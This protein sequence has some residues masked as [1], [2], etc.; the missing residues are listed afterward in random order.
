MHL[1]LAAYPPEYCFSVLGAVQEA[2]Q[3]QNLIYKY[4]FKTDTHRLGD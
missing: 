1:K 2:F 3:L 4:P